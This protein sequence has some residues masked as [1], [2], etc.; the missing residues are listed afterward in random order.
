MNHH[1]RISCLLAFMLLACS[2]PAQTPSTASKSRLAEILR[3]PALQP[4][5][6]KDLFALA[7]SGDPEAQYWLGSIYS[8]GRLLPLDKQKA[9]YWFQKSAD[10]GYARAEFLL[11]GSRAGH[12]E[13]ASE[14]CLWAAAE[15]GV[16]E[17]Q[18]WLGV[19]FDQ[20]LWFGVTDEAAA[21]KWFR[22]A[23][24]GGNADAQAELCKRYQTG[25]GVPVDFTRAAGWCRRAAEHVPD[26]GGASQGRNN[27]G[28]LYE[29][30]EGVPQDFV[31]AYKWLSLAG[32]KENLARIEQDMTPEQISAGLKLAAEWK[33]QHPDPAIY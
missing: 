12:D 14:R 4:A 24:E 3:L 27:L 9:A 26:L 28:I 8:A 29:I 21:L 5:D 7:G 31:Q 30:G 10:Q 33:N 18:F 15:N 2:L 19:A 13:L 32:V 6:W 25:E 16:P 11:C 17:A 20:H 1:L 22:E 23:A